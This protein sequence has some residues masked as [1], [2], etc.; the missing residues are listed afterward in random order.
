MTVLENYTKVHI[1]N[2]R[3]PTLYPYEDKLFSHTTCFRR[4]SG[5]LEIR[6]L[7]NLTNSPPKHCDLMKINYILTRQVS[8]LR[9]QSTSELR[10]VYNLTNHPSSQS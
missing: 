3:T 4:H 2:M 1:S 9:G 6:P 5:T 10:T 8:C 7:Y